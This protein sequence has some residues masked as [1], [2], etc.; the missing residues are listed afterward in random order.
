MWQQMKYLEI[1]EDEVYVGFI[2]TDNDT[3]EILEAFCGC[4]GA[5]LSID[6]LGKTWK[7]AEIYSDWFIDLTEFFI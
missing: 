7:I 3:G 6:E 4:C 1:V 2:K 5:V